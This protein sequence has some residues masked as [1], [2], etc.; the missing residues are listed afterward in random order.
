MLFITEVQIVEEEGGLLVSPGSY[1]VLHSHPE[2]EKVPLAVT[3]PTMVVGI[4]VFR[5]LDAD[6]NCLSGPMA[7]AREV[8]SNPPLELLNSLTLLKVISPEALS[9]IYE[10]I[11]QYD[12]G[13]K[14]ARAERVGEINLN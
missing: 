4:V 2:G 3:R 1:T 10:N 8:D 7:F 12:L 14:K 11:D 6:L 9:R 13:P 5:I